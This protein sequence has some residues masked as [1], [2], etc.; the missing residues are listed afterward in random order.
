VVSLS[1]R[2][3]SECGLTNLADA[4][5]RIFLSWMASVAILAGPLWITYYSRS[6]RTKRDVKVLRIRIATIPSNR[7][8][9]IVAIRTIPSI[10]YLE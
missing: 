1:S 7:L 5:E 3:I 4:Q 8:L 9:G 10:D 6:K 2:C